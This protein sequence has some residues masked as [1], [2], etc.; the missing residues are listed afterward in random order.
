MVQP[1][2][3]KRADDA[4]IIGVLCVWGQSDHSPFARAVSICVWGS[5][6]LSEVPMAVITRPKMGYRYPAS[7]SS[8][9]LGSR[10]L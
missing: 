1:I 10:G 7:R 4:Q 2:G 6:V 9:G 8:A 5:S 3:I